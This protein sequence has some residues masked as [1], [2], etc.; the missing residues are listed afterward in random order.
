L[1][2]LGREAVRIPFVRALFLLVLVG[3]LA[4]GCA[5]STEA[6]WKTFRDED[7]SARYPSDWHATRRAL[8]PVTSP[9]QVLAIASYP[10]PKGKAGADGCSPKEALDRLPAKGVFLFGWEYD[11]PGLTGVRKSDFPPRP[12]HFRLG[13]LTGFE[14]LGPSYVV[15]F[16][17][18]GRLLQIH[19]VLGPDAGAAERETALRVLDSIHASKRAL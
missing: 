3:L 9:V 8:T 1:P 10:L 19:V 11:R 13:E 14:C 6:D 12:A 17:E 5:S 15:H 18:G 16:R 2:D 7:V 4:A